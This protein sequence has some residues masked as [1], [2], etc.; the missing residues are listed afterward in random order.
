MNL[1]D[2]TTGAALDRE[3][4]V[5]RVGEIERLAEEHR[6]SGNLGAAVEAPDEAPIAR[7]HGVE[8]AVV[9]TEIHDVESRVVEGLALHRAKS[10]EAPDCATTIRAER[11]DA[12]VAAADEY[13]TADGVDLR[14]APLVRLAD[15]A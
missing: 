15:H 3:Q 11:V 12:V 9:R 4:V 13:P 2:P 5:G 7:M 10:F 14:A 6:F 8:R 1:P